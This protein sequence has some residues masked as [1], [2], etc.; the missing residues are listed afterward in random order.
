MDKTALL[1]TC[2]FACFITSVAHANPWEESS[3]SLGITEMPSGKVSADDFEEL[4]DMGKALFAAQFT[5][6]DGAGRPMATQ[7]IIPTKPRRPLRQAFARTSG[8]DANSC[9]ACHNQPILGGAG[10]FATNVFV[11]ETS[12]GR[13]A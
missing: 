6:L 5:S 2:L 8:P 12:E 7:A 13:S 4:R 9:G 11:S 1:S 3:Q 10:D